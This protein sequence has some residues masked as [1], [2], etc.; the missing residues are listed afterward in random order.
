MHKKSFYTE[1]S[2]IFG[3]VLLAC[4]TSLMERADFGLS[5]VVAPAYL[6]YRKLS[7]YFDFVSFGMMEYLFQA[8][9]LVL[10]VIAVRRFKFSYLFSFITA[11][12]YGYILNGAMFIISYIPCDLLW[13]RGLLYVVGLVMCALAVALVLHT[14]ISPEVYELIVKEV[15]GK[16]NLDITKFKTIYDCVSCVVSVIMSF[17]FFG[18]GHFEGIKLGTLVCALVNGFLIGRFSA[19]LD[20]RYTFKDALP[21]RKYFEK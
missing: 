20:K 4:S 15:P 16:Y 3:I 11:V 19:L 21:L 14:Y 5:M 8:F 9:L 7:L 18:F 17:C 13:Q 2:Y 10:L 6:L 12:L 1:L